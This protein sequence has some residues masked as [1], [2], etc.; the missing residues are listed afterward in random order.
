MKMDNYEETCKRFVSESKSL[1]IAPA[2]CGKTYT[3]AE[4]LKYT[5][6]LHLILT[7]THAGVAALKVKIKEKGIP[8]NKYR[9]ETIDS[10]AQRYVRFFYCGDDIPEQDNKD[11]YFPFIIKRATELVKIQPIEDII[12]L[13]YAGLFVDEYQDCTKL[14][15]KF[16]MALSEILPTHILGDPL[17][18]IFGFRGELVNFKEDLKDF[19]QFELTEP[20]RWKKTNPQLGNSLMEIREKLENREEIDLSL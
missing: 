5:E 11:T 14:Q 6:G 3:I 12:K 4:C 20:W 13:T 16:I 18:G 15:H 19:V 10:F 2:G 17:Q 9:I 8:T 7:H 1:L